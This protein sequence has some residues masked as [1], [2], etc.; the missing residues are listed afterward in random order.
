MAGFNFFHPI[1]IRYG[2]L[3]PQGHVN[4][5]SYLTYFEQARVA[6]VRHL[7]LWDGQTFIDVGFILADAHLNFTA[8]AVFGQPVQVG[9]CVERLGNKS[10]S[11]RYLLQ[12]TSSGHEIASG[13]T[14]LVAYNYRQKITI[15]LPDEWREIIASFEGLEN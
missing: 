9:V 12:E 8:P 3:D 14:V 2:D 6:Y 11:M 5:A 10:F 15:P 13:S 1:E 4:N 7:G